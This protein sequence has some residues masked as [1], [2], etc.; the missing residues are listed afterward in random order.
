MELK[1]D[2]KAK[3]FEAEPELPEKIPVELIAQGL[4]LWKNPINKFTVLR[5]H[6]TADPRKRSQEWKESA[7]AG[8]AY[9]EWL[10]E[11]EIIWSS[12][13]GIPVY[14]DDWSREF[15]VN[16]EP[17]TYADN[18]PII[19]GWDFGL[20]SHGMACVFGQLL[21]NSRL[22]IYRE[23]TASDMGLERF[24][25]EVQRLSHEW[26]PRCQKY[27]DIAD[28]QGWARNQQD[29]S[30]CI[31]VMRQP[32]LRANPIPGLKGIVGRRQSVTYFLKANVRG[33]P[34]LV[35]DPSCTMLISGF[36]GGYHFAY[37]PDGQLHDEPAKNE[38]SHP[39]DALQYL[40]SKV[41]KLDLN[42]SE[43][44]WNIQT[45]KYRFKVQDE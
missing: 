8:M 35:V 13:E 42:S 21:T 2:Y 15:H 12:F 37:K 39:H 38:Y 44:V 7:S 30:S 4:H 34:K 31:R 22:F 17:L 19:R 23:L 36:D 6:Y 9:S 14:L 20:S 16:H 11:Y 1:Q 18:M 25:E 24:V 5:I 26:F 41:M 27:Y 33:L 28:P 40:C 43:P 32:P 3:Q 10:R 45:P 29:K